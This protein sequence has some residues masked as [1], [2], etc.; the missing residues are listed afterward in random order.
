M[1]SMKVVVRQA[2]AEI[3]AKEWPTTRLSMVFQFKSGCLARRLS[4]CPRLVRTARTLSCMETAMMKPVMRPL[5]GA[6]KNRPPSFTH[7][8]TIDC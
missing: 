8:M 3:M 1:L 6:G 2:Q 4:N 7:L 5:I